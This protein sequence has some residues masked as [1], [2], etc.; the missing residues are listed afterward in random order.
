MAII[1][2]QNLDV[3]VEEGRGVSFFDSTA[4]IGGDSD[5]LRSGIKLVVQEEPFA[6]SHHRV[7][8][9]SGRPGNPRNEELRS[10]MI[11][12][13][14]LRGSQDQRERRALERCAL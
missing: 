1:V 11:L 13:E 14:H 8:E 12:V 5:R 7:R 6:P 3:V 2:L 4:E 9:W 10:K